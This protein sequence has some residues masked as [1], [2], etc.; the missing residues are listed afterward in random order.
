MAIT[1]IWL[2]VTDLQQE[3]KQQ[4]KINIKAINLHTYRKLNKTYTNIKGC[5]I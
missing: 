3:Q 1:T 2:I 5:Q 4:Q